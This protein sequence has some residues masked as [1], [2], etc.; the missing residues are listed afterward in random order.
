MEGTL[1][2]NGNDVEIESALFVA[3]LSDKK[4]MVT[5]DEM[6]MLSTKEAGIDG[7]V[8][9]LMKVAKLPGITRVSP[10]TLRLVF[11]Q[12]GASKAAATSTTATKVAAVTGDVD[13]LIGNDVVLLTYSRVAT[14]FCLLKAVAE[15]THNRCC[16]WCIEIDID[17]F[18][19]RDCKLAQVIK[20]C[21]VV[22]VCVGEK[23][24]IK[25][26]HSGT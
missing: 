8:D 2:I 5:T 21:D 9:Q 19:M 13:W 18:F 10:V 6:I 3:R 25:I 23:H 7:G 20:A 1:S 26:I 16:G 12:T 15:C 14:A 22:G 4:M 17:L 24:R 11:A